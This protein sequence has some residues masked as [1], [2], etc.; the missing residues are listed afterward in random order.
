M[1]I[2]QIAI[3]N[4]R[5]FSGTSATF[6]YPGR[7]LKD[8]ER[9]LEH[10][11]LNLILGNNGA[12]KSSLLKSI[13]LAV[14]GP[15]AEK[16]SPY[17]LVRRRKETPGASAKMK[18]AKAV[19]GND[20][21]IVKA[22][23][24]CTWQDTGKKKPT[25][26][27]APFPWEINVNRCGD[28]ESIES[29]Y[30]PKS[31]I[32]DRAR[33]L[34]RPIY[35]HSSPAFL[36]VGYGAT[37]RVDTDAGAATPAQ[38]Q[39]NIPPRHQRIQSLFTEGYTLV[40]LTHWLPALKSRN[41]GRFT[42][43][44]DRIND[45]LP[46]DMEFTARTDSMGEYL[47]AQRG[48]LVPFAALSDGSRAFIGWVAD[49]LYHICFG[50]PSG[51]KLVENCGIVLVDEIDL[52]LHPDWQRTVLPRLA[53]A[54]PN[55]QFIVT[56]HSPIVVGTLQR[57]N[58]WVC[59]PAPDG[60]GS[61]LVQKDVGVNGLNAD[62][63][64]LTEYFG[65]ES[66]RAPEKQRRLKRLAAAAERRIPGKAGAFL[67]S[68]VTAIEDEMEPDDDAPVKAARNPASRRRRK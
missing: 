38:K 55:L 45:L 36:S 68:L 11:N 17:M 7:V 27:T 49:M 21:A 53:K 14:L 19:F 64:L 24:Q 56:S 28:E 3:S 65:I 35:E 15:L 50:C 16:F 52:H 9:K 8:G 51:V 46:D 4:L 20:R 30:A 31:D 60:D 39:K 6:Q 42:Q 5:V 62:Q 22:A 57:K 34:W 41:P 25:P 58:I 67:K 37:R 66:S 1:Y 23:F 40:S 18:P 44:C 26:E 63:I 29:L 2:E 61:I 13:A 43:V 10:P 59:E 48:A 33:E 32:P 54:F 47:F 12:G